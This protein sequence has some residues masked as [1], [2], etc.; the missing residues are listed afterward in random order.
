VAGTHGAASGP[1][2][3][4]DLFDHATEVF[5]QGG[6]RRGANMAVL[7]GSHPDIQQFVTAKS[8]PGRLENF[9]LSIGVSDRFMRS[10]L[11]GADVPPLLPGTRRRVGSVSA[12]EVLDL[13]AAQA[14][15]S[16]DPGLLFLDRVN[17]TNPL[18]GLGRIEA[19]N[20]CGEVPLLPNESCNLGSINLARIVNRGRIDW[21]ALAATTRMAVRFL[22]D[23]IEVNRYPAQ[24][25]DRAA[26]ASRKIGLGVMGLA[27]LLAALGVPYDSEEAIRIAVRITR[28]IR[29]EAQRSSA[30]LAAER[31]P[32]P[33]W[34]ASAARRRGG[35]PLPNAQLTSI[36]PPARSRSSRVR[37]RVS[38][39]CSRSRMSGAPSA[40][41]SSRSIPRSRAPHA[42]GG[43]IRTSP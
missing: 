7:D 30:E 35:P 2:A 22:D 20:P 36:A 4:I 17:R 43:S 28:R 32:F 18:P 19:T 38:S 37:P 14:R 24:E 31:G 25:L 6:R 3:Y 5:K 29:E 33:L 27:E 21:D 13:A 10:A 1:L 9:N 23:V 11:T 12:P 42:I 41:S 15:R 26:R 8:Q 34:E 16:G 40:G 39:R